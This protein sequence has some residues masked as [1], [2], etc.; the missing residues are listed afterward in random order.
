MFKTILLC[1]DG[2]REGRAVLTDGAELALRFGA[3]AHLL[4]VM[5]PN[6]GAVVAEALVSEGAYTE[7]RRAAEEILHEGT[8]KLAAM[9]LAAQGHMVVGDPVEEIAAAARRVG[10]DLIVLGHHHR[11]PL[12]RWWQSSVGSSLLE[13]SPCSILVAL[14]A[15]PDRT[16]A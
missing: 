6:A 7:A 2:S 8:G 3:A 16:P 15:G 14:E 11:G 12:A 4:A 1:Y 9:G 13:Q 5:R 10:A